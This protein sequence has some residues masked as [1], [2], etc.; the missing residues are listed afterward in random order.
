MQI[1]KVCCCRICEH[2]SSNLNVM[3]V[4]IFN[5]LDIKSIYFNYFNGLFYFILPM[6]NY[7]LYHFVQFGSHASRSHFFC[8]NVTMVMA[9]FLRCQN[10]P[11]TCTKYRKFSSP[12]VLNCRIFLACHGSFGGVPKQK[13]RQA[14]HA[15]RGLPN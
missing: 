3:I 1:T 2:L 4:F 12:A 10:H 6:S 13:F 14:H 5:C 9:K 11:V 7:I 15:S 8:R